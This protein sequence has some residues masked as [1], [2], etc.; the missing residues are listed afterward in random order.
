[1]RTFFAGGCAGMVTKT[2][3]A[4]LER[5]KILCQTGESRG[6]WTTARQIYRLEGTKGF[7]R[8]NGANVARVFPSKALLFTFS[9]DIKDALV[10]AEKGETRRQLPIWKSSLAGAGAGC[11]AVLGTCAVLSLSGELLLWCDNLL[12]HTRL[13]SDS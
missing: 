11:C 3:C 1:V 4:P 2:A 7:W 10:D 5:V 12:Q 8:G 13:V 6:I 9:D